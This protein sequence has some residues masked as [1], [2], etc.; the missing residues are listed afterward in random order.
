M[1]YINKIF[2]INT[3]NKALYE[4]QQ[5]AKTQIYDTSTNTNRI[6]N[7]KKESIQSNSKI[8]TSYNS[9]N[10]NSNNHIKNHNSFTNDIHHKIVSIKNV[11][12]DDDNIITEKDIANRLN[13]LHNIFKINTDGKNEKIRGSV[14][15]NAES[16]GN[17]IISYN[18]RSN[19]K[20]LSSGDLGTDSKNIQI[21]K[22]QNIKY[23]SR[24]NSRGNSRSNSIS[25]YENVNK[26]TFTTTKHIRRAAS[27]V[28]LGQRKREKKI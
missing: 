14:Y 8:R 12:K 25:N 16:K 5:L 4:K 24:N 23:R 11:S 22:T 9:N 18:R 6:S 28:E 10:N 3:E 13:Y 19:R 15:N 17:T 7:M 2:K 1:N 27:D 21:E 20:V 26:G